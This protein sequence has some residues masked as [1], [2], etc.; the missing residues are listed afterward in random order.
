MRWSSFFILAYL[1]VAVQSGLGGY[2]RIGN[3]SPDLV[4]LAAVFL[5]LNAP[6]DAALI[7]CFVLGLIH[8]LLTLQP[9]GTYALGYGLLGLLAVSARDELPRHHPLTHALLALIGGAITAFILA[10]R[11]WIHPPGAGFGTGILSAIYTAVL[12]PLLVWCL[13]RFR[14]AFAFGPQRRR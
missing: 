4:L 2:A 12:A 3:A 8:D 9:P 1:A 11:G 10:V 7:G 13:Q 6:R 5:C 14:R